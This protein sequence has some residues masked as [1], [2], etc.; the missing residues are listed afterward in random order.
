[1][2][3]NIK[4]LVAR[5]EDEAK[6]STKVVTLVKTNGI[7]PTLIQDV[8]DAIQGRTPTSRTGQQGGMNGFGGGNPFGGGGFGGGGNPFGGGGA[9][10]FGGGAGGFGTPGGGRIG[11]G[12]PGGGAGGG[13]RGGGGF[14]GGAAGRRCW[15]RPTRRRGG[16]RGGNRQRSPDQPPEDL[17]RG[18][19]FFE[20]GD[21]DVPQQ[22]LLYDPYEDMMSRRAA[23]SR[24]TSA[25]SP[26]LDP[27]RLASGNDARHLPDV[28]LAQAKTEPPVPP[29]GPKK[30]VAGLDLIGPRGP[31]SA[32][33]LNEFG[34]VI[35]TANN[36]A[37]LDL[38][39]KIIEQ[40]Q[41]EIRE[42]AAT[43][44]PSMKLIELQNADAVEVAA[45]VNQLGARAFVGPTVVTNNQA[46]QANGGSVLVLPVAKTNSILLFGGDI[47]FPYY[48]K[49]IKDLDV[50]NVLL[51]VEIKIKNRSAQWIATYL[52]NL[53]AV[54]YPN[55]NQTGNLVRITYNPSAN[56]VLVQAAPADLE[57]IRGM[58]EKLDNGEPPPN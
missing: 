43:S 11:G 55:E 49:L 21:M 13:P 1:M 46:N 14:G 26:S 47:R 12:G 41:K 44:G 7:D 50:R 40:L 10:R 27:I 31:V 57:E 48:E 20:Q 45:T 30:G 18:P 58:I 36:Q 23:E 53:Y 35:I 34:R 22:T 15:W 28:M 6:D 16:T 33:P 2:A 9:G 25:G 54:R 29:V 37:D 39:L 38:V 51:P 52:T 19:D 8:L 32:S 3:D 17:G 4:E 24:R 56:S 5:L 42:D